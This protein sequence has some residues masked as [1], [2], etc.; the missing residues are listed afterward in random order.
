M[1]R[2]IFFAVVALCG[3]IT[4]DA[5]QVYADEP[6]DNA[7]DVFEYLDE[8]DYDPKFDD[9][10]DIIF[11]HGKGAFLII[12]DEDDDDYYRLI[13]ANF[14]PLESEAEWVAS[15]LAGHKTNLEMKAAK[16]IVPTKY[17]PDSKRIFDQPFVTI[18]A[19]YSTPS[20]FTRVIPRSIKA[21]EGAALKFGLTI[22]EEMEEDD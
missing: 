21:I 15:L 3:I 17:K 16:V 10:G 18:E 13:Y 7:L 5:C 14:Q 6:T 11:K 8:N 9:D 1:L 22:R 2:N 4:F 20:H 19:Y 12:F